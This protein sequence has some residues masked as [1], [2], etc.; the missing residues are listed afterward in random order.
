MGTRA[1]GE[2]TAALLHF[3]FFRLIFLRFYFIWEAVSL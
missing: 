3:I 1:D 2:E